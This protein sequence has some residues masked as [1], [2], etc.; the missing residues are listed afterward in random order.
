[1]RRI[2]Q[3]VPP[4]TQSVE[5]WDFPTRIFHWTLVITVFVAF[6]TGEDDIPVFILH[7]Y[8][9]YVVGLLVVFRLFWGVVGIRYA[10]FWDFVRP[11]SVIRS[12]ARKLMR[13]SPPRYI[14][15]NP[16]GGLMILAILATLAVVVVTGMA[17]GV[18]EGAIIPF[19]SGMPSWIAKIAEDVHEGFANFLMVL[20]AIHVAGVIFDGILT[21][22]NLIKAMINGHK[23][24]DQSIEPAPR[25]GAWR[26][27]FLAVLL[28]MA[29]VWMVW[30]TQ[31]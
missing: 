11:W 7:T 12:Y 5:I 20:V 8:L 22:E 31:F 14:G 13:L 25:V 21:G 2:E 10:R 19:F 18:D 4:P 9:G 3:D 23:L 16:L 28:G 26:S 15:H 6:F 29:W 1:M 30:Q 17:A 24:I 27:V